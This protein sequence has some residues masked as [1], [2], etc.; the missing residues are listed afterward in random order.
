[1]SNQFP[2]PQDPYGGWPPPD[3]EPD[4]GQWGQGAQPPG[5]WGQPPTPPGYG[6]PP[7]PAQG[8]QQPQ[9]QQPQH[10]QPQYPQQRTNTM[11]LIGMVLSLVSVPLALCCFPVLAVVGAVLGHVALGQIRTSGENG[12]GMA[13]TAIAVGWAVTALYVVLVVVLLLLG[14]SP[15]LVNI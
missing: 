3:K 11:A 12:R 4:P 2:P 8:W 10:Q 13:I 5:Q 9:Y 14:S 1:M 7:P 6:Y 15:S